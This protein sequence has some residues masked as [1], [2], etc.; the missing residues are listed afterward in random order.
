LTG[1]IYVPEA[2]ANMVDLG[3]FNVAAPT[4]VGPGRP[5]KNLGRIWGGGCVSLP[6]KFSN[7]ML[8]SGILCCIL[9]RYYIA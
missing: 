1:A 9:A 6:R 7:L 3:F 8:W 2:D 5:D 4:S